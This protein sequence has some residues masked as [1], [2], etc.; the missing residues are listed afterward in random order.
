[1]FKKKRYLATLFY[2]FFMIMTLVAAA[3]GWPLLVI[4]GLAICQFLA[5]IWYFLSYIP[6]ARTG[7]KFC[8]RQVIVEV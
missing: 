4:V 3:K 6:F 2:F 8:C 5:S 7:I 1:M